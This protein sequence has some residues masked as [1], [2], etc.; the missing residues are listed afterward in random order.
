MT[1]VRVVRAVR[2]VRVVRVVRRRD[3]FDQNF[4]KFWYKTEWISSVQ[5]EKSRKKWSTFRG[6]PLFLVALAPSLQFVNNI[7]IYFNAITK[8]SIKLSYTMYFLC[9]LNIELQSDSSTNTVIA[10]TVAYFS[11]SLPK[12][13]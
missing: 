4:W 12:P 5:L 11:R 6:G 9:D 2:V 7:C 13:R 1:V 8:F 10:G 3:P